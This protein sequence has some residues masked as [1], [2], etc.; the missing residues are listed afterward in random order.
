MKAATPQHT[1][2]TRHPSASSS[3]S[4]K[5]SIEYSPEQALSKRITD[6]KR[7]LWN[8]DIEKE[9]IRLLEIIQSKMALNPQQFS[10]KRDSD[11]GF[12]QKE[13]DVLR[14]G[15]PSK[16]SEMLDTMYAYYI[17]LDSAQTG[18]FGGSVESSA[19]L[20]Q[21]NA[22]RTQQEQA[23]PSNSRANTDTLHDT[24]RQVEAQSK[25]SIN[26]TLFDIKYMDTESYI[27]DL[28]NF[29]FDGGD[30]NIKD[31][32]GMTLLY[33]AVLFSK[34]EVVKVLI[35]AGAGVNAPDEDG[36]TPLIIAVS[37]KMDDLAEAL[38]NAGADVNASNED[39]N[40][41]LIFAVWKNRPK[42]VKALLLAGAD[43][44]TKNLQAKTAF[45]E[46]LFL[47]SLVNNGEI[48]SDLRSA[49]ATS[50]LNVEIQ[51]DA[52]D[53]ALACMNCSED[54]LAAAK[55]KDSNLHLAA[56]TGDLDTITRI[57]QEES[58]INNINARN[59]DGFTPLH[60]AVGMNHLEVARYL[61]RECKADI[62]AED[63]KEKLTPL[64]IA[65]RKGYLDLISCIIEEG[66]THLNVNAKDIYGNTLLMEAVGMGNITVVRLLTTKF[67]VDVNIKSDDGNTPLYCAKIFGYTDIVDYLIAQGADVSEDEW[68]QAMRATMRIVRTLAI[69]QTDDNLVK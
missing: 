41:P 53:F 47:K 37:N 31:E 27:T 35:N 59:K 54:V 43:V 32:T 5:S 51:Y 40:T 61:I 65:L 26:K 6:L 60:L 29:I 50:D 38:I 3:D 63:D 17:S 49:G 2:T 64:H 22:P 42:L 20:P 66:G 10:V 14:Q 11:L 8:T 55:Q 7:R 15:N 33:C 13:I 52:S 69:N 45:S 48:L 12:N 24:I 56:R 19:P 9:K 39:G 30:P 34:L 25:P 58:Q 46:A 44:H 23:K 68:T 67:S 16:T 36:N 57:W 1:T 28:N 18:L 62:N 21:S 4:S